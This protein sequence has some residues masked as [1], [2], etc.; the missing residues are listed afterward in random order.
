[1]LGF[2][3]GSLSCAQLDTQWG[4]RPGGAWGSGAG[5]GE[6]LGTWAGTPLAFLELGLGCQLPA[7]AG[8]GVHACA[9]VCMC[10]CERERTCA[11]MRACVRAPSCTCAQRWG[12]GGEPWAGVAPFCPVRGSPVQRMGWGP[13]RTALSEPLLLQPGPG[14]ALVLPWLAG[15]PLCL[16]RAYWLPL[17]AAS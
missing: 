1:M 9:C 13:W 2:S 4:L 11:Y 12:W 15:S 6:R 5:P 8:L 16:A 7:P 10:V 17:E 14:R 3:S